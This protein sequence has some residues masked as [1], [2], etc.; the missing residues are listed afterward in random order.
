MPK[1]KYRKILKK[2]KWNWQI[3]FY[4]NRV[5]GHFLLGVAKRGDYIAGHDMTTHPSL[6]NNGKPRKRY[7]ELSENPNPNDI[8][9]SF[10]YKKLR[11]DIRVHFEDTLQKRLS[12]RK[13]WKLTKADKRRIKKLD[14]KQIK[15]PHNSI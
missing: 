4:H 9:P 1:K 10:I 7:L 8:R 11:K 2:Q 12:L 6:K 5:S 3:K 15:S 14:K 13:G